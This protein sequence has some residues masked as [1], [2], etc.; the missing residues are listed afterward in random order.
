[1]AIEFN[2]P[3]TKNSTAVGTQR[4][5]NTPPKTSASPQP[6]EAA[7]TPNGGDQVAISSHA[8][9]IQSLETQIRQMPEVDATRVEMIKGSIADGSF[10]VD[11]ESTAKKMLAMETSIHPPPN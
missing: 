8:Q 2:K 6:D 7:K 5:G 10:K 9:R 1:M 11:A 4:S 3:S